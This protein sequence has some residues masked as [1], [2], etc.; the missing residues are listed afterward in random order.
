MSAKADIIG[1]VEA[2]TRALPLGELPQEI[3]MLDLSWIVLFEQAEP[4]A[5]S[6][7]WLE[8]DAAKNAAGESWE[9]ISFLVLW[10]CGISGI[11]LSLL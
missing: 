9:N 1:T 5:R 4:V 6:G 3:R 7:L 8:L 2:G 11:G 10:L